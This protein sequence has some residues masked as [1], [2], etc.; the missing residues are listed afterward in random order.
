M[1]NCL[2]SIYIILL[3]F[4]CEYFDLGR[5]YHPVLYSSLLLWLLLFV[6]SMRAR[7][8][9]AI[10]LVIPLVI[11]LIVQFIRSIADKIID[12][13]QVLTVT[14]WFPML[15]LVATRGEK[16]KEQLTHA[17]LLSCFVQS[18]YSLLQWWHL[19]Q[20]NNVL[21]PVSGSFFNPGPLAGYLSVGI[22]LSTEIFLN[23]KD[24]SVSRILLVTL[25]I[26]L[27]AALIVARSR[28]AWLAC[29]VG[30]G[31][32]ST[33]KWN[34]LKRM[35]LYV[36]PLLPLLL[37]FFYSVRPLSADGR[38]LI[39]KICCQNMKDRW[40]FGYGVDGFRQNYM[41]WQGE[42]FTK[43]VRPET[44]L[45]LASDNGYAFNT[46]LYFG[47]NYGLTGI[48]SILLFLYAI[49]KTCPMR[50]KISGILTL[51][52][53]SCFSYPEGVLPLFLLF[54]FLLGLCLVPSKIKTKAYNIL[55][56]L[57]SVLILLSILLMC[58]NT[59]SYCW[60]ER[61]YVSA[62][63]RSARN[64]DELS[65][66]LFNNARW[67]Y[68]IADTNYKMGLYEKAIDYYKKTIQIY[69][70]GRTFINMGDCYCEESNWQN[71]LLCYKQAESMLP[72]YATPVYRQ[73][74]I[75]RDLEDSIQA[76][77]YA[78]KLLTMPI[79]IESKPIIQ[80]KASASEYL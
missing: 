18:G 44:E 30:I 9:Y 52:V 59:K 26:I 71:A 12:A 55:P 42:Y 5:N 62:S 54:P 68:I 56:C 48:M 16:E 49:L 22:V 40:M 72:A 6:D 15:L 69:P 4:F 77:L 45:L 43:A 29:L 73:F 61:Y 3:P 24:G 53:F 50:R 60:L 78:E 17:L 65:V 39:W 66:L 28:A 41:M 64:V 10:H 38:L 7:S 75:Y 57:S 67:N 19:L 70:L 20:P 80:M 21:F 37:S 11:L 51:C 27:I 79:K 31:Y 46:F 74:E 36:L 25:L 47:V 14:M 63:L 13:E 33:N 32:M 34:R 23:K 1:I 2:L 58:A 8:S 76:K 35:S